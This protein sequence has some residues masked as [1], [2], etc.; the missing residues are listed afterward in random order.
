MKVKDEFGLKR[1]TAFLVANIPVILIAMYLISSWISPMDWDPN[2]EID[3]SWRYALGKFR[4]LGISL[5]KDA[6][7]TYG[8][9]AHWFGPPMGAEHYQPLPYY[10]LGL[11]V[12]AILSVS[13]FNLFSKSTIPYSVKLAIAFAFP[14]FPIGGEIALYL[15]VMFTM[16]VG[17]L[18]YEDKKW[19]IIILMLLSCIGV[20]YK[21]SFGIMSTFCFIAATLYGTFSKPLGRNKMWPLIMFGAYCIITYGLFVV[22]S[23]SFNIGTYLKMGQEISVKYSEI[24]V[25]DGKLFIVMI[26]LVF[27]YICS[28]IAVLWAISRKMKKRE[29]FFFIISML[30]VQYLLFKHGFVRADKGH[31]LPYYY[32]TFPFIIVLALTTACSNFKI[33]TS[34]YK[35]LLLTAIMLLVVVY[36]VTMKVYRDDFALTALFGGWKSV[37]SSIA[38]GL[39]GQPPQKFEQK[40]AIVRGRHVGLYSYLNNRAKELAANGRK[41]SITFYPWEVMF[42][43]GVE[44]FELKPSPSLQLYA[45]GPGSKAHEL[46]AD[47]LSSPQRPDFVVVGPKA[48]DGRSPVSALTDLLPPL[49]SGYRVSAVI[50][51]YTILESRKPEASAAT[52]VRHYGRSSGGPDEFMLIKLDPE[53]FNKSFYWRIVTTLFKAP[54]LSVSITWKNRQNQ[55]ERALFR[56]YICQLEKGIYF[57]PAELTDFFSNTFAS[58]EGTNRHTSEIDHEFI[59]AKAELLKN[60]GGINLSVVPEQLPLHVEFCSFQ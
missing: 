11:V 53:Q 6:Y 57:Y 49:Y 50:D 31:I 24:M 37:V 19:W 16:V 33:N 21:F 26:I 8:P 42:M 59:D 52:A 45:T 44:G 13:L 22:T 47:F 29:S 35:A 12:I 40:V 56:S 36:G 30:G 27:I 1:V 46:E 55:T 7:F 54:K 28:S 25:R 4:S 15:T 17:Y 51:Q 34:K 48:I 41:P 3:G 5:G 32:S 14:L 18:F 60:G 10:L 58:S 20:N 39:R 2:N 38:S 43:E 9:V 23:G